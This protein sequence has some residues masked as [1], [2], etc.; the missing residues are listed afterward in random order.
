MTA[1]SSLCKSL[2]ILAIFTSSLFQA[3][4]TREFEI[5]MSS[6][7]EGFFF[8][9]NNN[10]G[11]GIITNPFADRIIGANYVLNGLIFPQGTIS[12]QQEDFNKDKHGNNLPREIGNF[13]CEAIVTKDLAFTPMGFPREGTVAELVTWEFYFRKKCGRQENTII[14]KGRVNAGVLEPDREDRNPV[15]FKAKDLAVVGATGCNFAMPNVLEKARAYL[16]PT[17]QILL[18]VKFKNQIEYED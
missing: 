3:K 15:G 10:D 17:G 9:L 16:S 1:K 7:R 18:L 5:L 14:V 8:G 2:L 12:K 6:E 13:Y 4:H 11:N